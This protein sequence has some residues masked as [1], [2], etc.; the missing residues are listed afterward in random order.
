MILLGVL[1][2]MAL[3]M[4]A[5]FVTVKRTGD[6]GWTDVF[7]TFGTGAAGVACALWPMAGE[8][9]PNLRQLLVALLVG[10]WALRLGTYIT[11]RVARGPEDARYT[12]LRELWGDRFHARMYWF[13]Q[14][15]APATTLL[16]AAILIAAR[17]PGDGLS[18]ADALGLALL[19]VAILGESLA[20]RQMRLFKADPA[21]RGRVMDRGLWGWS[22]HPNYLFEWLAWLAY[23][24]IAIDLSGAYTQGWLTLAAPA[25]M[26]VLLT[27]LTGV[28]ALESAML[29]S[30]GQAYA[31]YQARVGAFFPRLFRSPKP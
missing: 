28:P 13:L 25:F 14:A 29:R 27:R 10:V 12:R 16:C 26:Y 4:A 19:A 5:A 8:S 23:P 3:V 6:G 1:L 22:R 20:D 11:L 2:F 17:R 7:W 18:V 31:E 15:Q 30:K 24:V 9:V 21:N